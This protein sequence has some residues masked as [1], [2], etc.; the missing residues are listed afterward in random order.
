MEKLRNQATNE[1]VSVRK[2]GKLTQPTSYY[3]L[4]N[5]LIIVNGR[6]IQV[7]RTTAT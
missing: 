2:H 3:S 1:C 4:D 7:H 6:P 5:L